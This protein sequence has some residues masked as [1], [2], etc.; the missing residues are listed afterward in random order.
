MLSPPQSCPCFSQQDSLPAPFPYCRAHHFVWFVPGRELPGDKVCM[1]CPPLCL[2]EHVARRCWGWTAGSSCP[3]L[4]RVCASL[5]RMRERTS[6]NW[7]TGP[8][9]LALYLAWLWTLL[10]SASLQPPTPTGLGEVAEP[11][12]GFL[13]MPGELDTTP[14]YSTQADLRG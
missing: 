10:A 11:G 4:S 6:Q 3:E 1:S 7:S 13:R 12:T 14:P 8:W 9:L 5:R 2:P